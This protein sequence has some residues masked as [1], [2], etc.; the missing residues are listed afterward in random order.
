MAFPRARLVPVKETRQ[1]MEEGYGIFAERLAKEKRGQ[2]DCQ[3]FYIIKWTS[4]LKTYEFIQPLF[5]FPSAFTTKL[6]KSYFL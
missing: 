4:V 1:E 2:D 3:I 5:A 6:L